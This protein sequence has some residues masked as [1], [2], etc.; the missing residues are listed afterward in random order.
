MKNCNITKRSF[1]YKEEAYPNPYIGIMSFQHFRGEA[2]YSD[3]IVRPEN[4][5]TETENYECYPIPEYVEQNGRCQG[6]YPDTTLAYI[7]ILWKE[8][9]PERGVYNYKFIQDI[10]DKARAHGQSVVFRLLGHSTRACDDVPEWLKKLIP[11]P[12]RPDGKRVKDSPTDPLYFELFL[13]AIKKIGERFDSDSALYAVDISLPGSWGE[14][15]KLELY[16]EEFFKN[17]V[18]TYTGVFKNTLLYGQS[19]LPDLLRY[20]NTKATVGWRGDGLGDPHHMSDIYPPRIEKISELWKTSPVSFEAYWW[21]CEWQRKGWDIDEIIERTL[22]WHISS[23]NPKS[24]PIPFEWEE[25]TKYW[26]SK[27]GYHFVVDSFE[28]PKDGKAGDTLEFVLCT[29][30]VGVAPIYTKL[31]LKVRLCTEGEEYIFDTDIDIR[32]W[33][34]GKHTD[35]LCIKLPEGIAEGKY[36]VQAGIGGGDYPTVYFCSDAERDGGF[37]TLGE[38]MVK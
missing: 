8:F 25:K 11:C 18:D 5:M 37:Y 3:C 34:P 20:A 13:E 38:I 33:L 15:H 29:E 1:G 26:L 17:I 12:E 4:N 6:Y 16:S 32:K 23:F 24:M 2:L 9:E 36:T 30:N 27:M 14:G 35:K 7:R 31:P 10:L 22:E 28:C 21:P 19:Y